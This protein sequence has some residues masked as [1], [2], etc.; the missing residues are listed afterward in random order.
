MF[1]IRFV[2]VPP[3]THV[4]HY[5]SGRLVREGAGLAFFCF[6][7]FAEL[8]YV[9]LGSVDVPF[10]FN[11]VTADFQDVTIQGQLTYRIQ[12]PKR[13]ASLLDFSVN[14]NG[15]YRSEDPAKL[16]DRLVQAAQIS[17]RSFTQQNRLS[18]LLVKSSGLLE[19]VLKGL[20][21]SEVVTMHGLEVLGL[22]ILSIKGTPEMSKALQADA[23]EQLLRKAD[24]AVFERRNA[25]VEME[26][27]IKESE[28][29]TEIAVELKKR[30]VRETQMAADIAV[31]QQRAAFVD[32]KVENEK[33]ESSAR[34]EALRAMLEPLKTVDW[35]T[36]M[37]TSAGA[38]NPQSLIAL[39]F[40]DLADNADKIGN[41]NISPELLTTL[42]GHPSALG[43]K[44]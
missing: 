26:R 22:S 21:T 32:Q 28:L 8:S 38:S 44:G 33:K 1:G 39:A 17:A 35:H 34:A 23:R 27:R 6:G 41:L 16:Q 20:R 19:E 11:E 37:A 40:R 36:L 43:K 2:K 15:L 18:D 12:D 42:L 7:P 14:A 31:E 10:V 13:A 30:Q 3:T 5:S 24:E 4:M 25:A 9:P 29:N